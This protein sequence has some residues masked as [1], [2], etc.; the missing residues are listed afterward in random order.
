MLKQRKRRIQWVQAKKEALRVTFDSRL[1]LELH[2]SKVTSAAGGAAQSD[3]SLDVD[4][5]GEGRASFPE[6]SLPDGGSG[7]STR[8]VP[9]HSGRDWAAEIG[10]RDVRMKAE[11][12]K[13]P[14]TTE[15]VSSHPGEKGVESQKKA[16]KHPLCQRKTEGG[17]E[18]GLVNLWSRQKIM[19]KAHAGRGQDTKWEIPN[20][21][22]VK[23]EYY[24]YNQPRQHRATE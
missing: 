9:G 12:V 22:T 6:D 21:A 14:E 19:K 1:K 8:V 13:T 7:G 24:Q 23:Y 20:K 17:L 16:S 3:A 10:N 11:H 5:R 18:K 15:E 4:D 2:G